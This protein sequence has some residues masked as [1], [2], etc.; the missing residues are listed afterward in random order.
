MAA[1]DETLFEMRNS[2]DFGVGGCL[3]IVM[4]VVFGGIPVM[5]VAM[6]FQELSEAP[7]LLPIFWLVSLFP[8]AVLY[9]LRRLMRRYAVR[10]RHDGTVELILPFKTI[11]LEPGELVAVRPDTVSVATPGTAPIRRR[12]AHFIGSDRSLKAS[13]AMSA[14]SDEQWNEFFARLAQA[15]PEVEIGAR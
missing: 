14:F 11:R 7:V 3:T 13:L 9:V 12:F 8:L 4:L 5:L 10:L 6:T 2:G 1:P 15:R